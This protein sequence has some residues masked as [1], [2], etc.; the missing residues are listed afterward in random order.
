MPECQT[1]ERKIYK[2]AEISEKI[3]TIIFYKICDNNK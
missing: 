2:N 1:T 3:S